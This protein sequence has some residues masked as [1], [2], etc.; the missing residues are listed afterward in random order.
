MQ[1]NLYDSTADLAETLQ[2]GG[3]NK[4]LEECTNSFISWAY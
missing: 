1:W 3:K 2:V 4:N